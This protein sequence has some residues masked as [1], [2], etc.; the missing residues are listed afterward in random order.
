MPYHPY[1]P[2][3]QTTRLLPWVVRPHGGPHAMSAAAFS[4]DV[5]LLLSAGVAV[6]LPNYRGSLGYGRAFAESLLGRA[7]EMDVA[8]VAALTRLALA[9]FEVSI[10]NRNIKMENS[11]TYICIYVYIY[12]YTYLHTYTHTYTYMHIYI[13]IVNEYVNK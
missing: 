11:Q 8:D 12:I 4:L 5:S 13:H 10:I 9:K 2:G 7:G 3:P 1:V 6:I